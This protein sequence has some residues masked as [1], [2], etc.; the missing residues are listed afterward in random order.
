MTDRLTHILQRTDSRHLSILWLFYRDYYPDD[1][2]CLNFLY[3]AFM[4]EP[5]NCGGIF[6]ELD[7]TDGSF[8]N[9]EGSIVYE[10][11]FIPRRMLNAVE[12]LVSAARDMEQIRKGK[13]IAC[14]EH[15]QNA[16]EN[17]GVQSNYIM[18][19]SYDSISEYYCNK[20][21]PKLNNV[22]RNLR[23]LLFNIYI[24]NFGRNYYKATVSDDLQSKI[25][26]VIKP[27]GSQKQ[28][29]IIVL[30]EFFYSFEFNDIHNLLFVPKWTSIDEKAKKDFLEHN[31]DLTVMSDNA[32]RAAFESLEPK[33]DWDR[34]FSNKITDI[35]FKDILNTIRIHRNSVAHCK[36]FYSDSYQNCSQAISCLNKAIV[37]A[38]QLT[39]EEDFAKKNDTALRESLSSVKNA[40]SQYSVMISEAFSK[41][42][43][44]VFSPIT[45]SIEEITKS[46]CSGYKI[47]PI[48][49]SDTLP[50][51]FKTN[52]DEDS[53]TQD[54]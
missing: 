44:S 29:E 54:G 24:V 17:S 3:D 30:Q 11:N 37:M 47:P 35:D 31:R 52:P 19:I 10:S 33:S 32:L 21:Y 8:I 49:I 41:I 50:E 25:K 6:R 14:L 2:S 5:I 22:E 28:K 51:F 27:R 53:S 23:K 48:K 12:R 36:F 9:D 45:L 7:K 34:F 16:L 15:I 43:P 26:G 13:D 40:F 18:V 20:I 1:E 38:I 42:S 46:I 39:E 4:T